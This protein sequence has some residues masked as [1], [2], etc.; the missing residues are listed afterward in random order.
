M[1]DGGTN[2]RGDERLGA[3]KSRSLGI[4][5][6]AR[7]ALKPTATSEPEHSRRWSV[8]TFEPRT[9]LAFQFNANAVGGQIES[10]AFRGR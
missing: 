5:E 3:Q 4:G 9:A 10:K 1:K 6:S 2:R 8:D 7:N